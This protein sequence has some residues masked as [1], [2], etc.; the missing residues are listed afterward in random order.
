MLDSTKNK[1]EKLL[2]E[3]Y[4]FSATQYLGE[5]W[6]IYKQQAFSFIGFMFIS[7]VITIFASFI[8]LIGPIANSLILGPALGV[9]YYIV[10]D[11]IARNRFDDFGA[12]FKGFNKVLQLGLAA[13]TMSIIFIIVMSPSIYS[14]YSTGIIEW[15][16][17]AMQNPLAPPPMEDIP[18]M[19]TGTDFMIMGLNF[20]P[21]LYLAIS[22]TFA[23]LFI[24]FYDFTFWDAIETSRRVVTRNWFGVFKLFLLIFGILILFGFLVGLLSAIIPVLGILLAVVG[25]LALILLSPVLACSI[26]AGFA[27]TLGLHDGEEEDEILDHLVE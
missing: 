1:I 6:D 23:Y 19:F 21:F 10:A 7:F 13:L 12:F 3:G 20:I 24:V 18:S 16:M 5:G 26:Y 14:L 15:Y 11:E 22:F 9:G 27:G 25:G 8:P 2:T 4:E 17:E